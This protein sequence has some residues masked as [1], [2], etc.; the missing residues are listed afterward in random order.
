M[1]DFLLSEECV[2]DVYRFVILLEGMDDPFLEGLRVKIESE[3]DT[4]I[5]A[6]KKREAFTRYKGSE[7][8]SKRREE[9][10]NEYLDRAGIKKDWR[11]SKEMGQ[12]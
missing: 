6:R 7:H 5:E 9:A 2:N 10:R 8:G 1:A 12:K 11:T 3:I 4:K